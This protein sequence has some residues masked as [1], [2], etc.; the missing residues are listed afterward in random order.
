MEEKRSKIFDFIGAKW[1][2]D[3]PMVEKEFH[4]KK[5]IWFK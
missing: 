1:I 5:M 2:K 3:E 4:E